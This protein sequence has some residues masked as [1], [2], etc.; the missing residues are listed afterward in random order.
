ML[1]PDISYFIANYKTRYRFGIILGGLSLMVVLLIWYLI[2]EYY[3]FKKRQLVAGKRRQQ[4]PPFS[5]PIRLED[6]INIKWSEEFYRSLHQMRK[7]VPSGSERPD[8]HATALATARNGGMLSLQ[9]QQASRPAEYLFLIESSSENDL[10]TSYFSQLCGSFR[11]NGILLQQYVYSDTPKRCRN[12]QHPEGVS[13]PYLFYHHGG[14]RLIII[15][16]GDAL[17]A[18]L[19]DG[20]EGWAD[21]FGNWKDRALLL[22]AALQEDENLLSELFFLAPA[23]EEGMAA[24]LDYFVEGSVSAGEDPD[25]FSAAPALTGGPTEVIQN[26]GE[27]FKGSEDGNP[28]AMMSWLAACCYYPELN[29]E[30]LLCCGKILDEQYNGLLTDVNLRKLTSLFWFREGMMPEKV[31]KYFLEKTAFLDAET[32]SR[33]VKE[34]A[35]LLRNSLPED[36]NS[37]AYE[38]RQMHITVLEVMLTEEEKAKRKKL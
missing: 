11:K 20:S 1:S 12:E 6:R 2:Q 38:Q 28:A 8:I 30:I 4:E 26:I 37:Y 29:W 18:G 23:T 3:R 27:Y 31:R 32:K 22:T 17:A 5:W 34:L 35:G 10:H 14:A 16:S 7:R 19:S 24:A 9:M 13:L 36:K 25:A 33:I 15:G 21:I